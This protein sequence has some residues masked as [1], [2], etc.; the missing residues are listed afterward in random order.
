LISNDYIILQYISEDR[1][2]V[3]LSPDV[4]NWPPNDEDVHVPASSTPIDHEK[5][6]PTFKSASPMAV[7]IWELTPFSPFEPPDPSYNFERSSENLMMGMVGSPDASSQAAAPIVP[8]PNPS[9]RKGTQGPA[10]PTIQHSGTDVALQ[11]LSCSV[12]SDEATQNASNAAGS[13]QNNDNLVVTAESFANPRGGRPGNPRNSREAQITR[14]MINARY[15]SPTEG[16]SGYES[17][18]RAFS[19]LRKLRQR[20]DQL[21]RRFGYGVLGL[22]PLGS[23]LTSAGSSLPISDEM[24]VLLLELITIILTGSQG[25]YHFLT[26][27]S[28]NSFGC[29]TKYK[30]PY[31]A[32]SAKPW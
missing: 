13:H 20:L 19:R 31:V 30:V 32:S 24:Y 29:L 25:S 7:N 26:R 17:R 15:P 12:Q 1:S 18:K 4:F 11:E 16:D 6:T 2:V 23:R 3:T 5:L 27:D 8:E 22:L 10:S 28:M 21:R 9:S 14:Q